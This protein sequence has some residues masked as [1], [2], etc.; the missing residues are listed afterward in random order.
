MSKIPPIFK[1]GSLVIRE[2]KQL[3]SLGFAL[4]T[5]FFKLVMNKSLSQHVNFLRFTAMNIGFLSR[6]RGNLPFVLTQKTTLTNSILML[7][8]PLLTG[9]M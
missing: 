9:Q 8:F 5:T 3:G 7:P 1:I 6:N 4:A 2:Q